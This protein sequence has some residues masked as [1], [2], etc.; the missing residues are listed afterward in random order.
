M[1]KFKVDYVRIYDMDAIAKGNESKVFERIPDGTNALLVGLP[2]SFVRPLVEVAAD[3][4]NGS[5]FRFLGE[6][7][8]LSRTLDDFLLESRVAGLVADGA[9]TL[10]TTTDPLPE[11]AIVEAGRVTVLVAADDVTGALEADEG[12][13]V[14]EL[15]EKYERHWERASTYSLRSPPRSCIVEDAREH[16]STAFATDLEATFDGADRL[17]WSDNLDPLAVCLLV[18]ARHEVQMHDVGRWGEHVGLA[19][20]SSFSRTKQRLEDAGLLDTERVPQGV[21]RPRQRLVQC[22]ADLA[23]VDPADLVAVARSRLK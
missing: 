2:S 19:S 9:L 18:G 20:R 8:D 22:D 23:D 17:R 13:F 14:D 7:D 12:P 5:Q 16:V 4:S 6:N 10:R 21:G 15:S 11:T 3:R 1:Q